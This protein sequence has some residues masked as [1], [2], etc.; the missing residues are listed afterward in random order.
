[1]AAARPAEGA[2]GTPESTCLPSSGILG[3]RAK[4]GEAT[5]EDVNRSFA[6]RVHLLTGQNNA[7]TARRLKADWR[8]VNKLI[9][10]ARI[11]RWLKGE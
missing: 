3:P 8:T 9:D 11:A 4:R 10:P 5:L 7:E 1:M 2:A 6:T